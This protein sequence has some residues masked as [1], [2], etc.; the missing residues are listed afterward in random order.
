MRIVP[1]S[2]DS[3]G[4]RL[5]G[6]ERRASIVAAAMEVFS[7]VG[8]QRGTMA[9]VARRVGVTEPVIFQNFGSKA[10]VFAAVIEAAATRMSAAMEERVAVN[11][12]VVGWLREM[13]A[14]A[15]LQ[16]IHARGTVGVLFADAMA[17][18]ADPTIANAA[19]E[20]HTV[21]VGTLVRLLAR[22]RR[23]GELRPDV[24]PETAAWWLL[25]LLASQGFRRTAT[26]GPDGD[27]IEAQ[28]GAM[29]FRTLTGEV[30]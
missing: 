7:E 17:L 29:T 23:E 1:T 16:R 13:L 6:V 26:P 25:S 5:S 18:T 8:Y 3:R 24:E 22:G 2:A 12:S 30:I 15:H 4:P 27:R 9:E 28:L 11:G 10:A 20:A 14:P 19:R 21:V